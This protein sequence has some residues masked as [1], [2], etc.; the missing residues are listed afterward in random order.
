M[1]QDVPAFQTLP[2]ATPGNNAFTDLYFDLSISLPGR[3]TISVT[4]NGWSV[5]LSA[6]QFVRIAIP[7][8]PIIV[9]SYH[10]AAFFSPKPRFEFVTQ[11]DQVIPVLYRTSVIRGDPR[12][13][14]IGEH[15][16]ISRIEKGSLASVLVVLL[17]ILVA[18]VVPLL[19]ILS[20]GIPE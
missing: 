20:R 9:V 5:R 15:R 6:G 17:H 12:T 2:R 10:F 18:D 14:S 16:G 7:P 8:G 4:A 1:G 19:I 11:P 3:S 13:L